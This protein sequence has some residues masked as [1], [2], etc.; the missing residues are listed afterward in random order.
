M[1]YTPFLQHF[2]EEMIA[3]DTIVSSVALSKSGLGNFDRGTAENTLRQL[4]DSTGGQVYLDRNGDVE[5]ALNDAIQM[6]QSRYQISFTEQIH[7]GKYHKLRVICTRSGVKIVG[8]LGRYTTLRP[9]GW[10]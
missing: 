8:P 9:E 4:A 7:D 1:D 6:A 2:S 10:K 5:K 3:S